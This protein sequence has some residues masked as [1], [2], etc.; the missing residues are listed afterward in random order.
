MANGLDI[1]RVEYN[2]MY[3][4]RKHIAK[5]QDY[6]DTQ[7]QVIDAQNA[8]KKQSGLQSALSFVG[9]IIG[10]P[11]GPGGVA[12]GAGIGSGLGDLWYSDWLPGENVEDMK[13][14]PSL[15]NKSR[16][17]ELNA[18]LALADEMGV[19]E[20]IAAG[21]KAGATAW[22]LGEAANIGGF[23]DRS[24]DLYTKLWGNLWK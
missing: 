20:H 3:R 5:A 12:I 7:K 21:A 14:D 8:R 4:A 6:M 22:T 24:A 19:Y 23:S 2:P 18:E 1:R 9:S 13:I 15:F 16:V 10:S 11:F 17:E